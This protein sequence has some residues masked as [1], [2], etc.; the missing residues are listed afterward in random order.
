MIVTVVH[1]ITERKRAEASLQEISTQKIAEQAAAL[2]AQRQ[3]R[4]A[5]L[6]LL[7]DA[8]A[9][10]AQAESAG[11]AL[12][13][14]NEQLGRFNRVAVDRELDMIGLK[15]QMNALARELGRAEP[16]NLAFADAPPAPGKEAQDSSPPA[17][18]ARL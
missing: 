10:R 13:E 3:A 11:A 8:R 12:A 6:N 9:A 2:E 7:E 17:A 18:G 5:A 15:R 14:R 1:D 16:F 4:L